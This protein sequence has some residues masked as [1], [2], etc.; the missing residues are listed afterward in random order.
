MMIKGKNLKIENTEGKFEFQH[1]VIEA[2]KLVVGGK[3]VL[4]V[5]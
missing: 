1:K 2:K 5:K 4:N 3:T